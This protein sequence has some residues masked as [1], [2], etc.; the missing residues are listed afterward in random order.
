MTNKKIL[1][2]N[3]LHESFQQILEKDWVE[4]DY[5]PKITKEEV[6][7]IIHEYHG[8]VVRSKIRVNK[9]LIDK[10]AKLEF[11]A[12]AGAGID[13]IDESALKGTNIVVFNAPEGNRDAVGEHAIGMILNLFNHLGSANT[14]VK[15]GIWMREEN[16]G[17]ELKGKTVGIVGFGNT[18][19]S[20]AKKLS[21]FDVNILAY[22]KYNSKSPLPYVK[23]VEL[24]EL[25]AET[26]VL[27][28]HV[29]LT[30]ETELFINK[31]FFKGFLKSIYVINTS[32]GK[33]VSLEGLSEALNNGVI[34]GAALD[35]LENEKFS[36]FTEEEKT[37]FQKLVDSGKVIFTPH[38]AG[39]TFESYEKISQVLANKILKYYQE[40]PK[41]V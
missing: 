16:R 9:D 23:M 40:S 33:V 34:Q 17:I 20:L 19:Q 18:G 30:S 38:V 28:I 2:V 39:W 41:V 10:A 3:D 15:N 27:S 1:V 25:Y 8:L 36:T 6:L 31:D 11:V 21:G 37:T 14:E 12:R 22:D 7:A 5:Q 4:I 13:N 35:V 29:P 32:R 26:D 24:E